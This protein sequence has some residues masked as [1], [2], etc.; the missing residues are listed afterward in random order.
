MRITN[1]DI[2]PIH[3]RLARRYEGQEV[4]LRAIDQRTV[5]R[6]T[7]DNGIVGYGDYR[8][9]S[10]PQS[11]ADAMVGRSPTAFLR[12]EVLPLGL[13]VACYDAV[14]K[15]LDVP[16]WQLMGSPLRRHI[17]V[18]AWTRPGSP[19]VMA[20]EI[21]RAAHDGYLLFKVHTCQ[22][23]DVFEQHAAIE[24]V[25]PEGFRMHY[26]FN[27]NR[28]MAA[29]LP[30]ITKLQ[31]SPKVAVVEDPLILSDLDGW[32]QLRQRVRVPILMHV[33]PVNGIQELLIGC[34]DGFV[35]A[36]YC[37]GFGD[38]LIRGHAYARA[39][40]YNVIQLTGGMLT[41]AFALHFASTLP[42][43]HT[44]N[45]V[46]QYEDDVTHQV[47]PI[48]SGSSPVPDGPGLGIEVDE[49]LLREL[50]ERPAPQ[51]PEHLG[52]LRLAGGTTVYTPSIPDVSYILG[53]EE[54]DIRGLDSEVWLDDGSADFARIHDHVRERGYYCERIH[55]GDPHEDQ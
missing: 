29:V 40:A 37:G 8:C 9:A 19:E 5:F 17:P 49:E 4:R 25:A 1:V 47:I 39:G 2:I 26:D 18:C 44:I 22:H 12:D 53:C 6:I 34:A 23:Y 7:C 43:G 16:A 13:G 51:L 28:T 11:V 14:G 36:E 15:H 20:A 45:L 48:D 42:T 35:I 41:K 10:P 27:S 52:I 32:R 50:A 31:D 54:G 38:A 30:I 24:D 21:Q 46:D 55:G 3:P 33:P